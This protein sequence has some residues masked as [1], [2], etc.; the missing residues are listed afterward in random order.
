MKLSTIFILCFCFFLHQSYGQND[1][2]LL[3]RKTDIQVNRAKLTINES[4]KIQIN[5]RA[6]SK[7]AKIEI[8]YS[9]L[10]K[11]SN[12]EGYIK[13]NKG[14]IVRKLA[15]RDIVSKSA[16]SNGTFY[17]DHFIKE[18]S[19]DYSDYPFE[20]NYSY[21]T[22][23]SEFVYIA[24]W[25]PV[26]DYNVPTHNAKLTVT[27][28]S[29][30]KI[31]ISES[32]ISQKQNMIDKNNKVYSWETG[33]INP[34]KKES[35]SS[36]FVSEIP[37]ISITPLN[38]KYEIP[39]SFQTWTS[40]GN[41]HY[42]LISNLDDLPVSEQKTIKSIVNGQTDKKEIVKTIY[43]Y[44]QDNT[45]Y[46]NVSLETGGLKPYPSSY[47]AVNKYGDCKALTNYTRSLL[48]CAGIRSFYTKIYAGE[49]PVKIDKEFPSQQFNH[50]ILFIPLEHDT[51]WLD[52]TSKNSF[53]YLGTFTQNRYAF[54]VDNNNSHFIK[55]PALRSDDVRNIRKINFSFDGQTVNADLKMQ[56]KGDNYEM[57]EYLINN[58]NKDRL[59]EIVNEYFCLPNFS[60]IEYKVVKSSKDI[61]EI[62]LNIISESNQ[63]Y[64]KYGQNIYCEILP[65]S[66]PSF[67]TPEKRTRS[68]K[69]NFP[70]SE[71]DS[72]F[73][74]I[75]NDYKY[76]IKNDDIV[77]ENKFGEFSY[78]VNELSNDCLLIVKNLLIHAGTYELN[79]YQEFYNFI[80]QIKKLK[81]QIL[82]K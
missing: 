77:I 30:F 34:I 25:S 51:I 42:K 22:Q 36:P 71:T 5:N 64:K 15:K 17:A 47:V 79:E 56:L 61:P 45:R 10:N 53:N 19:L 82:L 23:I 20:I 81:N 74:E 13:N 1:A 72:L 60:T 48:S 29:D 59:T 28:P 4:I 54:V 24:D 50:I 43:H 3:L 70:I 67:E 62:G 8:P 78:R 65:F 76:Q 11:I 58:V 73:Y 52:C 33:Y 63:Y 6:G 38:F 35:F 12:I 31:N 46:I 41:W 68:L 27:V 16:I 80:E 75:P 18:F 40:F 7:Y 44:V 66:F 57:L 26:I 2:E 55:T 37:N 39:G 69:F 21:Q 9:G 32:K 49:N 14:I